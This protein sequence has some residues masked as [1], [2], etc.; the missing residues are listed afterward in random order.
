MDRKVERGLW[1]GATAALILAL[2]V[3]LLAPTV[4]AQ[5]SWKKNSEAY[6]R[7]LE[8][9]FYII[10]KNFVD[11][12][13]PSDLFKGAIDGL[14][15]SLDDPYSQY[16]DGA[17]LE[18]MTDTTD[19]KYGGVG[20]YISKDRFDA[21]SPNGRLPY[22]KVVAP[23]EDT[24]SWRAGI[25]AGDHIYSI[26]GESAEGFTTRDVSDRLRG[27]PGTNVTVTILRGAG[28]TFD[29]V[30]E[31]EEIEIPTVKETIIRDEVGYLRIIEFTPY[32]AGR[33]EESLEQF[34]A[35]GISSVIV[36][37]RSNPG[38]LL[39][40]VVDVADHFFSGGVVVTTRYRARGNE[41][42]HRAK[43]G[44]VLPSSVPVVVLIDRGSAS[45]SEI[46]T[47]ALKDRGRATIIGE[48]S[49]GKGSVQQLIPLGDAAIKLTMGRY[50]TPGGNDIDKTGIEPDIV[51]AEPELTDEQIDAYTVLLQ[52]NRIASFVDEIP[53]P[54]DNQIDGFIRELRD[55]GIDPGERIARVMIKREV[56]RRLNVPPVIDLEYDR[57]LLEALEYLG[58]TP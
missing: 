21:E 56:E 58:V 45:A 36:D 15:E 30:L 49:Y 17:F 46:L 47:G 18:Q 31:R 8:A 10:Q 48:T 57:A 20:L 33:V 50:Y 5:T 39:S 55:D 44:K 19:G 2:V 22:V 26:E 29:V 28:I 27:L 24:P 3:I 38:G 1:I 25:S 13:E 34:L 32:T 14:F 12:M 23:I 54:T 53:D 16:L 43:P 51:V 6:I 52:E 9:A 35:A 41:E 11:E 37:V 42:V 4:F 40:S 7:D